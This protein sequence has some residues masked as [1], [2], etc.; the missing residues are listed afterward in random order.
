MKEPEELRA[1]AIARVSTSEQA[2][3]GNS[4]ESQLDWINNLK[5]TLNIKI[6][7][8]IKSTSSGETFP[9]THYDK[10]QK[11]ADEYNINCIVVYAIDRFSRNCCYGSMLLQKLHEK[12]PLTI[13]TSL[14]TYDYSHRDDRFWVGLL[15]LFAEKEQGERLE[16]TVRG[17]ITILKKGD[18][19]LSPPFGYERVDCKLRLI[20]E[21]RKVIWFIFETFIRIGNYTETAR[22][23]NSNHGCEMGFELNGAKIKKIIGDK[24]YLGYIK[25]GDWEVGKGE[26]NKPRENL[27]VIDEITYDKAQFVKKQITEQYRRGHAPDTAAQLVDE[28]G[29]ITMLKICNIRIY[30]PKCGSVHVVRNG[31]EKE[32]GGGTRRLK[33]VCKTCKH[34]FRFPSKKQMKKLDQACRFPC[35]KCHSPDKIRINLDGNYLDLKCSECGYKKM[36]AKFGEVATA[37]KDKKT[38]KTK[39]KKRE[40]A[41]TQSRI[42]MLP[43]PSLSHWLGT[44]TAKVS[45][46]T[47]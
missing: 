4:M 24:V 15:L 32:L 10:I 18:W 34:P 5:S 46:F 38:K 19:P 13:I 29:L 44:F 9:V 17:V 3:K 27:R 12:R 7:E 33:F 16:R 25:W 42:D 2:K 8:T 45:I 43:P 31:C 40:K 22:L 35:P 6:M 36:F 28:Y 26:E 14:R 1:L 39:K 21:Y 47:V 11:I 37:K 23:A 30:C 20:E 41:K